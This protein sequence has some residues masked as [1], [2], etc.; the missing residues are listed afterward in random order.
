MDRWVLILQH[1]AFLDDKEFTS[2]WQK[3]KLK[4]KIFYVKIYKEDCLLKIR[5]SQSIGLV[6]EQEMGSVLSQNFHI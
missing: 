3:E 6:E 2:I 4:T 5:A 1:L